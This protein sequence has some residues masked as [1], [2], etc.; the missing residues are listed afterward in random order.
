MNRAFCLRSRQLRHVEF[1][2]RRLRCLEFQLQETTMLKSSIIIIST[3]AISLG[4]FSNIASAQPLNLKPIMN[5]NI[6]NTCPI[7]KPLPFPLKPVN[8]PPVKILP[9]PLL[10]A[11]MPKPPSPN[12]NVNVDLG[13]NGDYGD[14]SI[15][16]G[17]G[18][19]IVRHHGFRKVH[20]VDCSGD[21]YTYTGRK[22]GEMMDIE[23]SLDGHIVDVS[24]SY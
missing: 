8:M 23:V 12:F 16:C 5:C 18:R 13:D 1:N 20:A 14:G 24:S 4:A 11:P 3:V 6:T 17:E 2:E 22:H 21:T 9:Y 7:M 15:S 19:S 10:P